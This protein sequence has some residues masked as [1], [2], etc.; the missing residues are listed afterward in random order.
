MEFPAAPVVGPEPITVL[1]EMVT[2]VPCS[3]PVM[4]TL[5]C[6]RL[7]FER[8]SLIHSGSR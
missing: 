8:K 2:F 5:K 6:L 1:P 4:E 7:R 3:F